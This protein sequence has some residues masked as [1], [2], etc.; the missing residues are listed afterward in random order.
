MPPLHAQVLAEVMVARGGLLLRQFRN[1][2]NRTATT[3]HE[4]RKMVDRRL[5]NL[6][7]KP[8]EAF[9]VLPGDGETGF[10]FSPPEGY[11]SLLLHNLSDEVRKRSQRLT[12]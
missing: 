12:G 5:V 6:P 9:Q 3:F 8:W 2:G 11:R 1:A 10:Q 7:E 4:A